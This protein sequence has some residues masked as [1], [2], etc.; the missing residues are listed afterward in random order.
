M[1]DDTADN[2]ISTAF[3]SYALG[4]RHKHIPE[5]VSR[6]GLARRP[7]IYAQCWPIYPGH[8]G[9]GATVFKRP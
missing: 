9:A 1:E 3:F 5:I 2:S 4:L 8:V 6:C 7:D